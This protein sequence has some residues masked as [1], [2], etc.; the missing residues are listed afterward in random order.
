M[1]VFLVLINQAQVGIIVRLNFFNRDWFNAIQNHDAATFWHQLLFVF[2][3]WAFVYVAM[4][5]VEFFMQS[6]LVIR[7]RRWLTDHFVS[8]WLARHNHYRISLVAGQTDNPDQ[9]IAEDVYRFINGGSD[10]SNTA[11]GIYDFSILLISTVSSLVSFAVVLWGLSTI[12]HAA[13]HRHRPARLSVLGRPD[14]CG[15]RNTDHPSDRTPADRPVFPAPAHGGRLP[16]L[17]RPPAR[18][19]RAGRASGRRSRR[20]KHGWAALRGAHRQLSRA[21][22]STHARHGLHADLW[23]DLADHSL[24]SSRR[25]SISPARSS[26]A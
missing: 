4:T 17:A 22:L 6:M 1:V 2:T 8:R 19:Y 13:R 20:A 14:L 18:I 25:R 7:W 21:R 24:S 15:L 16:L 5:V 11:Y 10:G 9:R 23:P 12:V 26:S 3:P